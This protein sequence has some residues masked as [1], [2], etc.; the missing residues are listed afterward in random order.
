MTGNPKIY[1]VIAESKDE[2]PHVTDR[3][4]MTIDEATNQMNQLIASP[5]V[6][7]VAMFRAVFQTGHCALVPEEQGR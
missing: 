2:P 6:I 7:R 1:G 3:S 4:L 5:Q